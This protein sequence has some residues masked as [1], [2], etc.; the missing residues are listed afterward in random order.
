[1]AGAKAPDVKLFAGD[2]EKPDTS[3][4]A[5]QLAMGQKPKKAA[6]APEPAP[7]PFDDKE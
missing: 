2:G 3:E 7:E 5:K 1:M 6:K 4:R